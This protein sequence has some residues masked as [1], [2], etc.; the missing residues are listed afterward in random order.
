M[1]GAI[2]NHISHVEGTWH[3]E[4][5]RSVICE[6]QMLRY[7]KCDMKCCDLKSVI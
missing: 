1:S 3:M 7:E 6:L 4:Y 5:W 2:D